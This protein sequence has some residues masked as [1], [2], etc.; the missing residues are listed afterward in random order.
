MNILKL[1]ITQSIKLNKY[2]SLMMP[3]YDDTLLHFFIGSR[4]KFYVNHNIMNI[5]LLLLV[6][7]LIIFFL[8][9]NPIHHLLKLKIN[10]KQNLLPVSFKYLI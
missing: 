10:C 8:K 5:A 3:H 2:N 9:I 7:Y 4:K 6:Q 1:I